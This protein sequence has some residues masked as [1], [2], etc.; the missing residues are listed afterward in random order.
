MVGDRGLLLDASRCVWRSRSWWST[1]RS[2]RMPPDD[3]RAAPSGVESAPAAA[4]RVGRG[5]M[6]IAVVLL[7]A[8]VALGLSRRGIRSSSPTAW[9]GSRSC[10]GLAGAHRTASRSSTT[11]ARSGAGRVRR[12]SGEVFADRDGAERIDRMFVPV[13]VVDRTRE[14]GR[15]PA[16]GRGRCRRASGCEAFPTLVVVHP[17]A[18]EPASV[19]RLPGSGSHARPADAG[20]V[21]ARTELSRHPPALPDSGPIRLP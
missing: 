16:R 13:R 5:L 1:G 9:T 10:R 7:A 20:G 18:G 11:S 2:C 17:E 4:A 14:D 12:C 21:S 15:N 3:P 8:R 6:V 19:H